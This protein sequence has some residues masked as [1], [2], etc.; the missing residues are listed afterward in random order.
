M[1]STI[2]SNFQVDFVGYDEEYLS[3]TTTLVNPYDIAD[4]FG[5][6]WAHGG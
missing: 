6:F 3:L 2:S 5:I 1:N 4:D